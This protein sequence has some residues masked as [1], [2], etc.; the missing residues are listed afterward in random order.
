MSDG[1]KH[2]KTSFKKTGFFSA[3]ASKLNMGLINKVVM[4]CFSPVGCGV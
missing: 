2:W 4:V 1:W 3:F